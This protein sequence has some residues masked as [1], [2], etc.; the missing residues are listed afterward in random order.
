M[1]T[2]LMFDPVLVT[3][4]AGFVGACV[5]RALVERG[6]DVHVMLRDPSRAWRLADILSR[7]RVHEADLIDAEQTRAVLLKSRPTAVLHLATHG[8][9]ESQADARA[10]LQTNILGTYNLLEASAAARVRVIVN[11]GSSSEYG[12]QVVPMRETSRLEPNSFYAVAKACQSHL[13]AFA[14]KKWQLGIANLRLFSVYGPWEAPTRLMPTLIRRA[15]AGLPLEMV[16]PNV[17]RD[18]VY[19]DDVVEALLDFARLARLPGEVINLGSGVEASLAEVVTVVTELLGSSSEVRWGA[20][21]AR[22]WDTTRWSADPRKAAQ[23]LKWHPRHTLRD[24]VAKLASW[25]Q[26]RGDHYGPH[27]AEWSRAAA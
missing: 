6:H 23:L 9:Y 1:T 25:M 24:G 20:M 17:A 8:A 18:Y 7:L 22:H 26:A 16:A 21:P 4:G 2:G 11:T 10:I 27:A 19:V 14:A 3:G 5:V 15:R 12:Y 13:C